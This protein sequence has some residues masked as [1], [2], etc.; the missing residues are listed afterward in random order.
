MDALRL[1]EDKDL[2]L[3]EIAP[4]ATPPV[5]RIMDYGKFK[6]EEAKRAHEAKLKQKIIQVK[7]VKFRPG[8][9]DGDYNVKLRNLKRFLEDGDKTKITLRFR[10][11]EMAHQEIGARMLERLKA[12]LEEIGQ[13]EQM[14]KMEGRQMVMV[15]APKKKK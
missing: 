13:V 9:D 7:E 11:R 5:A 4:N 10:G 15:L 2:D 12:D 3:V 14:P 8:T 6:Y 1:A